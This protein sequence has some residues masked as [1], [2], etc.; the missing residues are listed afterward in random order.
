MECVII[1]KKLLHYEERSVK[2]FC[3]TIIAVKI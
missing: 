3:T 1:E 2:I